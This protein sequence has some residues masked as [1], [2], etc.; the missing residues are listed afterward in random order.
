M[1]IFNPL[2]L[3]DLNL[4]LQAIILVVL[5]L[6]IYARLKHSIVKHAMLMGSGIVLHT[7]AIV[8][9]MVP[10][11]LSMGVLLRNLLT[12]FAL[13]TIVHATVGS[14]VELMGIWLVATWLSNTASVE[15][16]FKRKNVMR[17]TI[18]LWL[19]ELILGI[20]VYMMLYL[21]A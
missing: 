8:A 19:T 16:C 4:I 3:A 12:G 11:L 17:V 21:P 20:Y 2:F 18:A 9:I 13:L 5:G 6:A 14:F 15:K 1:G 7:V 10:S